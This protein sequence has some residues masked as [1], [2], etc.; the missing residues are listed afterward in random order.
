MGIE[1][2]PILFKQ[3]RK[4]ERQKPK[5]TGSIASQIFIWQSSYKSKMPFSCK[6]AETWYQ[7]LQKARL[8]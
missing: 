7:C 1:P 6:V 4:R 3:M 2:R 5:S 8:K